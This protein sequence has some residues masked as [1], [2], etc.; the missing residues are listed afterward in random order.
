MNKTELTRLVAE[1]AGLTRKQASDAVA[2]VLDGIKDAVVKDEKVQL[3]GFGTFAA[4]TRAAHT[5]RNPATG[6]A[7]KVAA[8]KSAVFKQGK[9]FKDALNVPVKKSKGKAKKK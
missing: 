8:S 3:L 7:I 5:G 9:A 2:A 4:K 1:K 6:E